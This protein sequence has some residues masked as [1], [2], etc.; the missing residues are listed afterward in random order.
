MIP[1]TRKYIQNPDPVIGY[2][3]TR[4][5]RNVATGKLSEEPRRIGFTKYEETVRGMKD[6]TFWLDEIDLAAPDDC[7]SGIIT[8]SLSVEEFV[9]LEDKPPCPDC[10]MTIERIEKGII[11]HVDP[12]SAPC[13]L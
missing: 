4:P 11:Y 8:V 7:R 10:G 3:T 13:E 9:L 6:Y 5:P 2:L 1:K 12:T